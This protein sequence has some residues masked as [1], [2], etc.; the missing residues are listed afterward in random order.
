MEPMQ[1]KDFDRIF[2]QRLDD[3]E[4]EPSS[5]SWERISAE[6]ASTGRKRRGI[7]SYWMAAASVVLL[8]SAVLWLYKPVEMVRLQGK[9]TAQMSGDTHLEGDNQPG[10]GI[11]E[12][13]EMKL[14]TS[15]P[16]R[17]KRLMASTKKV[18]ERS[19]GLESR[20][21]PVSVEKAVV[22]S[23]N[24]ALV[25]RQEPEMTFEDV[26]PALKAEDAPAILALV[27]DVPEMNESSPVEEDVERPRIKSIGGLVN[28]VIAQV[29]KRD[30]KIIEFKDGYEG[31]HVSGINLGP[32]KFKSRE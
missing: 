23:Q 2:K 31:S 16:V 10:N 29:D 6:L 9:A 8:A 12:P 26:R 24:L 32:L 19:R 14:A 21:L 13:D 22:P 28:F 1:D 5:R 20:V 11:N 27:D 18:N 15:P 4:V 30:D 25:K 3:F 17:N 7:P